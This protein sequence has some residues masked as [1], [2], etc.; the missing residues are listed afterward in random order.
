MIATN[1]NVRL[2]NGNFIDTNLR[3]GPAPSIAAASSNSF[4]TPSIPAVKS[5]TLYPISAH[6]V[7]TI[8]IASSCQVVRNQ[9]LGG[10]PISPKIR[11][12][13]PPSVPTIPYFHTIDV[14]TIGAI[15][16]IKSIVRKNVFIPLDGRTEII[17]ARNNVITIFAVTATTQK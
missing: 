8:I 9:F 7:Y 1:A 12:N 11:F 2:I 3:T 5:T 17:L 10:I 14:P 16:G 15:H 6:N 13:N 4:G